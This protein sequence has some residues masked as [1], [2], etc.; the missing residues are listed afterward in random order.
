MELR[1]FL[2]TFAAVFLAELGDKTQLATLSF[3]AGF[4]SFWS[5]FLGSTL[6]LTLSSLVVALLGSNLARILPFR[7]I[8]FVA[9]LGFIT[10]GILLILRNIRG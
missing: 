5:V 7:W 1:T 8:Q 9:G 4:K 6:A 3:A 10:L 2:T